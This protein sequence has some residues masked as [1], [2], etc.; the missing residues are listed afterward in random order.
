MYDNVYSCANFYQPESIHQIKVFLR[1]PAGVNPNTVDSIKMN[2]L[3]VDRLPSGIGESAPNLTFFYSDNGNVKFI[4]RNN[5]ANMGKL[6]TLAFSN[7]KLNFFSEDVFQEINNLR[8][9]CLNNNLIEWLPK[10]I[11]SELLNLELAMLNDNQLTHLER[12]LFKNNLLLE[13]LSFENNKIKTIAINFTKLPKIKMINLKN[14]VCIKII[15][16]EGMNLET[17][18][19]LIRMY[20]S[21]F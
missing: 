15:F 3:W 17:M 19:M 21:E 10:N 12:D 4:D 11:F 16:V 6:H 7:H 5:F 13:F 20:C 18:Q 2:N 14:N 1:F 9:L 8:L